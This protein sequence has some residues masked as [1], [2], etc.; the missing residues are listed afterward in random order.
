MSDGVSEIAEY[1]LKGSLDT[2]GS[3]YPTIVDA[4]DRIIDGQHR[5]KVDPNWP[6]IDRW[7]SQWT[8]RHDT[9]MT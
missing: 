5:L 6:S 3:L 4:S 7:M 2:V 1:D 8:S 9:N